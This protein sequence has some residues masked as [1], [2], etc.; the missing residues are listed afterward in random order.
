MNAKHL[1][2]NCFQNNAAGLTLF[3]LK[4]KSNMNI[5]Y[6]DKPTIYPLAGGRPSTDDII[7]NKNIADIT[8]PEVMEDLNSDHY[9]ILF[10]IHT[11]EVRRNPKTF[12]DYKKTN[13]YKFKLQ[14]NKN[15]NIDANLNNTTDI[16]T[17]VKLITLA[18][19]K[20]KEVSIPVRTIQS[21]EPKF[22]QNIKQL[23]WS[24]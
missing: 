24:E 15:I 4:T 7:I 17:H 22:N 21:Y 18:F 20:A 13:W 12:K 1:S 6:P 8:E 2:W 23:T 3:D 9:P 10:K 16:E 19:Q 11:G 14:I 5:L